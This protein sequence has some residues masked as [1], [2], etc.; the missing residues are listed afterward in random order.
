MSQPS[1]N[2]FFV[3][4]IIVLTVFVFL[5]LLK[6]KNFNNNRQNFNRG[7][8]TYNKKREDNKKKAKEKIM[9]MIE[10]SGRIT[11][12]EVQNYLAV[13]DATATNYLQELE[14]EGRII[15]RGTGREI[16]YVKN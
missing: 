12:G 5:L 4:I 11:N 13:S 2:L 1:I 14:N 7:F 16:Y 15:Q 10:K 6:I 3:I 9:Q 8:I